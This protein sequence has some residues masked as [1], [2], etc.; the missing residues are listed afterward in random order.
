M[1]RRTGFAGS[2]R[3]EIRS[4]EDAEHSN[5]SYVCTCGQKGSIA[6]DNDNWFFVMDCFARHA[7]REIEEAAT[8]IVVERVCREGTR[9]FPNDNPVDRQRYFE[10]W[11]GIHRE[12]GDKDRANIYQLAANRIAQELENAQ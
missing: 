5:F 12:S 10:Y 6:T 8:E 1:I 4:G 7:V 3:W 11:A 9:R 2:H